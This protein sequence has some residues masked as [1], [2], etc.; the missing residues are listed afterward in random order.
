MQ[1]G[2]T[3]HFVD[4]V[5]L[6]H[7]KVPRFHDSKSTFWCVG[8]NHAD[9]LAQLLAADAHDA[10]LA[11]QVPGRNNDHVAIFIILGDNLRVL[12]PMKV[13]HLL[14]C[15]HHFNTTELF[16]SIGKPIGVIGSPERYASV[17]AVEE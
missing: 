13:N 9:F 3:P 15:G 16:A 7:L 1:R 11:P 2:T 17:Y 6:L 4:R 10:E 8:I 5:G 12:L 14:L